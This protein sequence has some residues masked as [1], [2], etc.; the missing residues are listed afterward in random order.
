MSQAAQIEPDLSVAMARRA[1]AQRFRAAEIETPELDARLLVGHALEL[2]HTALAAQGS[3]VLTAGESDRLG[4]L[5]RRRLAHEPVARILG[6]KEFWG[7]SFSVNA[8]T[9]VPRPETETVIDAVLGQL[10]A[11]AQ[12]ARSLRIAD[13]GT[14][15]GAL[16]LALL[17]EIPTASG[18]GTDI[19]VEAL[20]CARANAAALGFANRAA[21][22]AG[23]YGTGL[24]CGIDVVVCNPP[25]VA[26]ADIVHLSPEVRQFDPWRALD[27]ES[28]GLAGYRAVA[29][30]ARRLLAPEGFLAVELGYGQV[31]AVT[32]IFASAGLAD[33]GLKHDLCG[34][35]RALLLRKAP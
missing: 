7:L 15:T 2:D 6:R 34:V 32:R 29:C 14:G 28:D 25:Y 21:F 19:S 17:S 9:L 5:M 35:P 1:I 30:D 11:L 13:L 31:E 33:F 23:D 3:R 12:P 8:E 22:V 26:R 16:L 20:R 27:G 10:A 18:V 24:A 4:A